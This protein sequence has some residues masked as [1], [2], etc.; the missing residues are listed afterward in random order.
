MAEN[1]Y[2]NF[3]LDY[4]SLEGKVAIITGANQ[5]LGEAYAVAYA[6][7]GADLYIPHFTEDIDEVKELVEAEGRKVKFIRGDLTDKE[8]IQK[9]VD[10]C[11]E[12][13][14]KI[15][16]L[17]KRWEDGEIPS[18]ISKDVVKKSK[19]VS[20]VLELYYEILKLVP[21]SYFEEKNTLQNKVDSEKQVILSCYIRRGGNK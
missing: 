21:E 13:Y 15:D 6:K 12:E 14:G 4:F 9:V 16:I 19:V 7:A 10:G 18:R 8:Y 2:G 17:I 1:K 3:S 5:G 20:D 11:M